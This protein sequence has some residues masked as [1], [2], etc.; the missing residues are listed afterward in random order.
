MS[1]NLQRLTELEKEILENPEMSTGSS[2][3]PRP[4]VAHHT[5]ISTPRTGYSERL[6]AL[7]PIAVDGAALDARMRMLHGEV[8]S[9]LAQYSD[10]VCTNFARWDWNRG[11]VSTAWPWLFA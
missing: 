1:S 4:T 11:R 5:F 9:L 3:I 10:T 6:R 8:S 7:Q 2:F